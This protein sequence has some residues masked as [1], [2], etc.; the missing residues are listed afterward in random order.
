MEARKESSRTS[1]CVRVVGRVTS[2]SL[3]KQIITNVRKPGAG[4]HKDRLSSF[5]NH[6]AWKDTKERNSGTAFSPLGAV[7][8]TPLFSA[9]PYPF[10]PLTKAGFDPS[11][12]AWPAA[13]L[14]SRRPC[15]HPRLSDRSMQH[16]HICKT[17]FPRAIEGLGVGVRGVV[18]QTPFSLPQPPI[19]S[20]VFTPFV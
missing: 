20:S 4:E 11:P 6:I 18:T 13:G 12:C 3:P 14:S 8:S 1:S 19:P 2:G 7:V 9:G 10:C 5:N 16:V 15:Q 17:R